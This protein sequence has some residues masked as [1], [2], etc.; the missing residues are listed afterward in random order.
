M[1]GAPWSIGAGLSIRRG[2]SGGGDKDRPHN[3]LYGIQGV[4]RI[5]QVAYLFGER[6]ETDGASAKLGPPGTVLSFRLDGCTLLANS[7]PPLTDNLIPHHAPKVNA[8]VEA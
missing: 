8:D 7:R 1:P 2:R 6:T 4:E 3:P 5:S